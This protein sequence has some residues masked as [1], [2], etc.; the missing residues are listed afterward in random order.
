MRIPIPRYRAQA[1]LRRLL[2]WILNWTTEYLSGFKV[3]ASFCSAGLDAECSD[4]DAAAASKMSVVYHS[5]E[6]FL[7]TFTRQTADTD[8]VSMSAH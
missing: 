8:A 6:Q 1:C 4:L 7:S 5:S 2:G 3:K